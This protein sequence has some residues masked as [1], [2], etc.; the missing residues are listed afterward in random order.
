MRTR[1]SFYWLLAG[2]LLIGGIGLILR[3]PFFYVVGVSGLLY[4]LIARLFLIVTEGLFF[5]K[6]LRLER[7]IH[8][9]ILYVSEEVDVVLKVINES[10][11]TFTDI[12]IHDEHDARLQTDRS[13]WHGTLHPYSAV[14]IPYRATALACGESWIYGTRVCLRSSDGLFELERLFPSVNYLRIYPPLESMRLKSRPVNRGS[15]LTGRYQ[16]PVR[17]IG[18]EFA[19]LRSYLPG[20]PLRSIEWKASVRTGQLMVREF[21]SEALVRSRFILDASVSMYEG[22][23]GKRKIDY[24][25]LMLTGL[26]ESFMKERDL[27]ALSA[28]RNQRGV[29]PQVPYGQ[30]RSHMYCILDFMVE[31]AQA[32]A[33]EMSLAPHFF[34]DQVWG[35]MKMVDPLT[36]WGDYTA[37]K[38]P[39]IMARFIEQYAGVEVRDEFIHNPSRRIELLLEHCRG[40][41]TPL[42][43]QPNRRLVNKPV[44]L[45]DLVESAVEDTKEDGLIL[46][47]SDLEGMDLPARADRFIE[48]CRLA[49][50]H[51]QTVFVVAP[52]SPGFG[53]DEAQIETSERMKR[54]VE[55]A[56]YTRAA[57]LHQ[58]LMTKL[59]VNGVNV[60]SLFA[61][62]S[63]Q[64]MI[65]RFGQIKLRK[66]SGR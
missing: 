38:S 59:R 8:K 7:F 49:Q 34:M 13:S 24:A 53:T 5:S 35:Y 36:C 46:I 23:V 15:M 43:Q 56:Y 20:D 29:Y 54:I 63:S 39:P 41:L 1:R 12:D 48:R 45:G 14:E 2:S 64:M 60:L 47:F 21:E 55:A 22:P 33:V 40:P 17:G 50:A 65:K 18:S 61:P 25:I 32:P 37:E 52:F 11:L 4:A 62:E 19:D 10:P 42:I 30:G 28:F 6:R 51:H 31:M 27:V 66:G 57:Y 16:R 9:D 44:L 58:E 3:I 26:I